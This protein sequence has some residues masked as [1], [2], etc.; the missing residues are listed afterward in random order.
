MKI[1]NCLFVVFLIL[2]LLSIK[3][4]LKSDMLV[5]NNSTKLKSNKTRVLEKYGYIDGYNC[6]KIT[7]LDSTG[8]VQG[9]YDL[10]D[11][12]AGVVSGETHILDDDTTFEAMSVAIRTYALY[13]T[14]NC[15]NPIINSEAHQVMSTTVSN[16]IKKAVKKTKGQVLILNG[17]LVMAEYDSFYMGSGFYC[18]KKFCYSTYSK[19]GNNTIKKEKTHKIKVPASWINDLS[20]GHGH[21]MSQYGALYLSQQGYTYDKIL[22]YFYDDNVVIGTIIKPNISGLWINNGFASRIYRPLRN[23]NYYYVNGEVPNNALE[24]EST[25]YVTSRANEILKSVN[26]EKRLSYFDDSNKYCNLINFDKSTDYTKP[27]VGSIISWGNHVAIVE[28]VEEETIDIT[29]VYPALGYYGENYAFEKLNINGK[30][31]NKE[32]NKEDRKYNCE[33]NNSGC[34]QRANDIKISD[35]KNRWGYDFKC[36]IYLID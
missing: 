32:T 6:K 3:I 34:F 1:K 19:A 33:Q 36:Y 15:K 16:K 24:G 21:G 14:N 11:Y 8:K 12:V 5:I 25:W 2:I 13:V 7:V 30:Y 9:K 35:L 29:E 18:D 22:K 27:K 23:N 10:E 4:S 31:Y 26:S 28:N 20:G 17:K